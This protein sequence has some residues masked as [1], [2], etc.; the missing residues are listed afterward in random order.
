VYFLLHPCVHYIAQLSNH[1]FKYSKVR[2]GN[3]LSWTKKNENHLKENRIRIFISYAWNDWDTSVSKVVEILENTFNEQ[4]V[5]VDIWIDRRKMRSGGWFIDQMD[6]GLNSSDNL[7]L[8][9]SKTSLESKPVQM[10]WKEKLRQGFENHSDNVFPFIVDDVSFD[11]MPSFLKGVFAYR[12]E[13]KEDNVRKL[14]GD[15]MF[16]KSSEDIS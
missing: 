2:I 12:Y 7:I 6:A 15:I 16:W 11:A 14:A 13:G 5:F 3:D 4:G 10:E 9:V 1:Y 8:M